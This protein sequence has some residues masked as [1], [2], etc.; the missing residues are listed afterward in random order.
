MLPFFFFFFLV[1]SSGLSALG[2]AICELKSWQ[3]CSGLD[4]FYIF[5]VYLV[6]FD[7]TIKC[8]LRS[9]G[10]AGMP[11]FPISEEC[12]QSLVSESVSVT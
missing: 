5:D 8:I 6:A 3:F 9:V 12:S 10:R 7:K 4:A 1:A 2:D 11:M